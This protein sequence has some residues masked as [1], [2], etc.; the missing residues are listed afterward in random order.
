MSTTA[1]KNAFKEDSTRQ[2]QKGE[3]RKRFRRGLERKTPFFPSLRLREFIPF[4]LYLSLWAVAFIANQHYANKTARKID[5]LRR[6][7]KDLRADY[8][9]VKKDLMYHTKKSQIARKVAPLGLREMTSSPQI[10]R[11]DVEEY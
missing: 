8:L 5:E 9:T 1:R 7:T 3:H 2:P 4:L 11:V 6:E 10:L